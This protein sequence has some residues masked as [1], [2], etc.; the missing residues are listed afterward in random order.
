MLQDPSPTLHPPP[1]CLSFQ[2]RGV[3][4]VL[5]I[6]S[7]VDHSQERGSRPPP[8]TTPLKLL[9]FRSYQLPIASQMGWELKAFPFQSGMSPTYL[10]LVWKTPAAVVSWAL[11]C[12]ED[13]LGLVLPDCWL[14][15][16]FCLPS[17]GVLILGEG[18][19][20]S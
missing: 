9:S 12:P 10:N 8:W 15:E 11:S 13:A 7:W 6:Y 3:L 2:S 18:G 17:S 4:F 14:L 20:H 5:P 16:S 19:C 1:A